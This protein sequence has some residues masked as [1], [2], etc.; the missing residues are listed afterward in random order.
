MAAYISRFA[1]TKTDILFRLPSCEG[2]SSLITCSTWVPAAVSTNWKKAMLSSRVRVWNTKQ[3]PLYFHMSTPVHSKH[4]IGRR[5]FQNLKAPAPW[6]HAELRKHH[7]RGMWW[8]PRLVFQTR[9]SVVCYSR[10]LFSNAQVATHFWI[11]VFSE[12]MARHRSM[13]YY[14]QK[15]YNEKT[16]FLW[17]KTCQHL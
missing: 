7:N 15:Y 9:Y 1:T 10:L 13:D 8:S 12:K 4:C 11:Q 17:T 14:Q 5:R 3:A 2:S 16:L 6:E